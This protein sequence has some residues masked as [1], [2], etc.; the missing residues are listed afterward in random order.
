M[1]YPTYLVHFNKNHSPKNGQFVSGDGDGDGQTEYRDRLRNNKKTFK[2]MSRK[3]QKQ[4]IKDRRKLNNEII[5]RSIDIGS[6]F[7]KTPKGKEL[8]KKLS[9][10]YDEIWDI[11]FINQQLSDPH[12]PKVKEVEERFYK[13]EKDFLMER[14]RYEVK[15]L[16]EEYDPKEIA[17]LSSG[18]V[19]PFRSSEGRSSVEIKYKDVDDLI[20][21]YAEQSYYTHRE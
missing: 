14:G 12:N 2:E 18:I 13:S 1:S 17:E 6:E 15:K 9:K 4:Y 5:N 11:N 3:E 8:H 10:S 16:L 19:I 20:E 21:K 7:D